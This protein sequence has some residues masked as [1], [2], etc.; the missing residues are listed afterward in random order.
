M[1]GAQCS[2][3]RDR[4]G[5]VSVQGRHTGLRSQE[6]K[7]KR[8]LMAKEQSGGCGWKVTEEAP[9]VRGSLLQ[10][11]QGTGSPVRHRGIGC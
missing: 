11:G 10:A 5:R 3:Y 1:P 4:C 7:R 9:G 2:R 8:G 6:N